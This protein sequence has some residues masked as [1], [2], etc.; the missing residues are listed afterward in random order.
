MLHCLRCANSYIIAPSS[1]IYTISMFGLPLC[2]T[3]TNWTQ[4]TC[5]HT[6]ITQV[7]PSVFK[8]REVASTPPMNMLRGGTTRELPSPLLCTSQVC[9]VPKYM[10]NGQRSDAVCT[11]RATHN[12]LHSHFPLHVPAPPPPP[13]NGTATA[14]Q[15]L[16]YTLL[17][18]LFVQTCTLFLHIKLYVPTPH[19]FLPSQPAG[20]SDT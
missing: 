20:R 18:N 12:Q 7:L 1:S 5:V 11:F 6:S 14:K 3:N 19:S 16:Q 2:R 10:R 4:H 15:Q 17:P 13:S 9:F 8:L